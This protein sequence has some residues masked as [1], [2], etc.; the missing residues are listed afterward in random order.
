MTRKNQAKWRVRLNSKLHDAVLT[1]YSK[2]GD[3]EID[4]IFEWKTIGQRR[5]VVGVFIKSAGLKSA[6]TAGD[7]RSI[8]FSILE[9]MER[10]GRQERP[11][12]VIGN[13]FIEIKS[14]PQSGKSLTS[15]ELRMVADLYR[16]ARNLGI[17]T[18]RHIAG[19]MDIS[20]SAVGKRIAAARKAG[21]LGESIGTKAGER[22][23][24]TTGK[25][26]SE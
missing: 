24:R 6:V 5:E 7:I 26:K 3:P 8:P 25:K 15:L 17:P 12:L 19:R 13:S 1:R 14:G 9:A 23:T 22:P 2:D 20:E 4:V 10:Q 18:A 11:D 16:E 21:F